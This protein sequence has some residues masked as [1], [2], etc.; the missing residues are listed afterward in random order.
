MKMKIKIGK[1]EKK[2]IFFVSIALFLVLSYLL[3][4]WFAVYRRD[5]ISKKDAKRLQLSHMIGKISEKEETEKRIIEAR[6][7]LEEAEKGL[8]PGDKPAVGTAE[9]QKVLKNMA[10]SSGIEIRSEKVINPAD[11]S[12]YSAISVEITFVSTMARLRNLL[13]SIETS[14]FLLAVPDMKIRVTNMRDPTDVQVNLT[15]KG[16]IRRSDE[17][18]K[19]ES[20]RSGKEGNI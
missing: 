12:N 5:L 16:I 14:P 4:D 15:V 18:E 17:G 7:E 3:Y 19:S 2:A 1:R 9:L 10:A 20:P 13:F 8:I 11:I 6:T